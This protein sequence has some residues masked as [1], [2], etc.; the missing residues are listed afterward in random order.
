MNAKLDD[1]LYVVRKVLY[2][3]MDDGNTIPDDS[4][5][6]FVP[7]SLLREL[8]QAVD[9]VDPQGDSNTGKRTT[10]DSNS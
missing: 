9:A 1:I 3:V 6:R 5:G 4:D 8:A 7:A 2:A 10:R